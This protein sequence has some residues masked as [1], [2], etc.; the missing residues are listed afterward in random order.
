MVTNIN[1]AA[2]AASSSPSTSEIITSE[3]ISTTLRG[4]IS[5]GLSKVPEVGWLLSGITSIF[6]PTSQADI[7]SIIR[8]DVQAYVDQQ[9]SQNTYDRLAAILSGLHRVC[10]DYTAAIDSQQSSDVIREKW[11]TALG[12]FEAQEDQFQLPGYQV[13]LLP[14]FA[15]MTNM[16]LSLLRDCVIFGVGWGY[17]QDYVNRYH[18]T[19]RQIITDSNAYVQGTIRDGLNALPISPHD[20]AAR[21]WSQTNRYNRGMTLQVT[22][23]AHFWVYFDP[24]ELTRSNSDI[25][26][27]TREIYSNP[28]GD[29]Q[30][31]PIHPETYANNIDGT[32]S[33]KISYMNIWAYD[34][35]DAVQQNFG[36]QQK[37]RLGGSGGKNSPPQG[38]NG[39]VDPDNPIVRVDLRSGSVPEEIQ[40]T[41]FDG[42]QTNVC[43]NDN[44]TSGY[45]HTIQLDGHIV[46]QIYING[47]SRY[48]RSAECIVVGFRIDETR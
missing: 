39:P 46:S 23:N 29:A 12:A 5:A 10:D 4:L 37:P 38:W 33:P 6:W 30:D 42:S 13:L 7:W 41:F 47:V 45:S 19:L 43:G 15:Q 25:P 8:D 1:T 11:G 36:D 16:Y 3:Q 48:Y 31:N 40:L 22:D 28:Y 17:T 9:L 21:V 18:E 35:V 34:R 20:S 32:P 44:Y 14:F 2:S 26:P 24:D 27:L